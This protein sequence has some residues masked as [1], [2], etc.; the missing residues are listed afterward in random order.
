LSLGLQGYP[1]LQTVVAK[2]STLVKESIWPNGELDKIFSSQVRKSWLIFKPYSVSEVHPF[3][4]SDDLFQSIKA[5]WCVLIQCPF[6]EAMYECGLQEKA[7]GEKQNSYLRPHKKISCL[8]SLPACKFPPASN[9]FNIFLFLLS[10]PTK[11]HFLTL[12]IACGAAAWRGGKPT[13]YS[14]LSI[15]GRA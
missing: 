12:V 5:H 7:T 4:Q 9:I 8:S 15:G 13:L 1:S 6:F 10:K 14:I 3:N 11:L 2:Y